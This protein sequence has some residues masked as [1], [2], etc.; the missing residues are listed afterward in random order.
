MPSND[1]EYSPL[2]KRQLIVRRT[3]RFW[4]YCFLGAIVLDV[5]IAVVYY[6]KRGEPNP[7][8]NFQHLNNVTAIDP[9]ALTPF[10]SE[11]SRPYNP[12]E[13]AVVTAIYSDIYITPVTT[14][15]YSLQKQDV[16]AKRILI[17]LPD[18]ISVETKCLA[19]AAG[20]ELHPIE[21]ISPPHNGH[22]TPKHYLDQ[23]TKL[24]IWKMDALGIKSLVY[25]DAD[26]LV[27]KNFDELFTLPFNLAAVPDVFMYGNAFPIGFNAGVLVIRPS[28]EIFN[29]MMAKLSIAKY[30]TAFAEQAFLNL[31]FGASV[32]RLPYA[33]NCNIVAKIRNPELWE[34]LGDDMRIVHYTWNKP[35]P[36]KQD[37]KPGQ[38]MQEFFE[39]Q[40]GM[41]GGVWRGEMLWWQNAWNEALVKLKPARD[42]CF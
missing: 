18:R 39:E 9:A 13:H 38:S 11:I 32:A 33:Y 26:T 29:D 16:H 28:T 23:Y 40:S 1:Y 27:L 21:R 24:N 4:R 37:R 12:E 41:Q 19:E 25:I 6:F 15:G 14:L 20:W 2:D 31:Y 22:G 30:R 7:L 5:I 3:A 10:L 36:G 17:Y 35:F 8:A 42:R 34:A